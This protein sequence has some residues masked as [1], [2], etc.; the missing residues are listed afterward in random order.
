MPDLQGDSRL[1]VGFDAELLDQL[2][3]RLSVSFHL[4]R[5]FLRRAAGGYDTELLKRLANVG[6]RHNLHCQA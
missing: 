6:G 2:S 1:V 4:L 5:E 3:A